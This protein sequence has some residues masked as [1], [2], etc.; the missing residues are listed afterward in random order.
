MFCNSAMTCR[1]FCSG[2][3][4]RGKWVEVGSWRCLPPSTIPSSTDSMCW[5]WCPA[6]C[7]GSYNSWYVKYLQLKTAL[8][9]N[10]CF[11]I[12]VGDS[13]FL[14]LYEILSHLTQ[15]YPTLR[16]F[17]P[18]YSKY[19]TLLNLSHLTQFYPTLLNLIP[20]YSILSHLTQFYPTLL[21]C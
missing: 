3:H 14:P 5:L 12:F 6:L 18:P 1:Y 21:V 7:H 16:N 8:N 11:A 19:P 9:S 2:W 4:N 20:L 13:H 10:I 17:I 15:F